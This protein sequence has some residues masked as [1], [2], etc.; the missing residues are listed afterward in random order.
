M[1]ENHGSDESEAQE[2]DDLNAGW[3]HE[4]AQQQRFLEE[5]PEEVIEHE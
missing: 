1:T 5:D 2:Q 3:A 4:M